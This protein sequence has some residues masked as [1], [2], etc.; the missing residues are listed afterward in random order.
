MNISW[1]VRF[2][3]NNHEKWRCSLH[4][5]HEALNFIMVILISH[6]LL[7]CN[8]RVLS[9]E[10]FCFDESTMAGRFEF[11]FPSGAR[12]LAED[13]DEPWASD[14]FYEARVWPNSL[15]AH[16]FCTACHRWFDE[17]HVAS[18][19]R[20]RKL[21]WRNAQALTTTSPPPPTLTVQHHHQSG[22]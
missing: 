13:M 8:M 15:Q 21:D 9:R 16:G 12:A 11:V 2:S 4:Y 1:E 22:N 17:N 6:Y 3:N 18:E 20:R 14:P 5:A 7:V 19:K 10:V